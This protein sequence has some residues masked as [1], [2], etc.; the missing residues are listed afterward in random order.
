MLR[1]NL[2]APVASLVLTVVLLGTVQLKVQRPMLLAERF[3]EGAGWVEL[4]ALGLYAAWMTNK[5]LDVRL[6][7]RWRRRL[8]GLFSAVFFAQLALG[9]CGLETFLMT[10]QLH[11]P[12][13]AMIVAGPVYRGG[14]LFM[15]ILFAATVLLVGPAWCSYLCYIGAWDSALSHRLKRPRPMPRWRRPVRAI[16]LLVVVATAFALRA[17]SVPAPTS[18]LFGAA[19]GLGGVAVMILWSRKTGAMSH[20]VTYCPIGFLASWL[21]RV[22]PFRLRIAPS[23]TDC[24]ACSN[25]CR[26]DALWPEDV[27]RRRPGFTCTLCGDCIRSCHAKSIGIHFPGL[28]PERARTVFLVLA[29]SLHACF[30]GV[31]RI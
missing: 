2:R 25:V 20:C 3:V 6:A 12:V 27:R 1:A 16:V 14:G 30:L 19:F 28:G 15:P 5:V 4:V 22:S 21:G 23:C 24:G 26:Y 29:V 11:L 18:I 10:G 13:P 17:C 9:L 31:A 7:A 8:W